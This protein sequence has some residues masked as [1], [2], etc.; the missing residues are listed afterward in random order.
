MKRK[1]IIILLCSPIFLF[2][3]SKQDSVYQNVVMRVYENINDYKSNSS[4][5]GNWAIED[6]EKMFESLETKIVN[7]LTMLQPRSDVIL[8]N[9]TSKCF[10]V[11]L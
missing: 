9:K 7:N 6:F 4:L 8:F 1:I 5:A 2:S 10:L 11:T 3:Q